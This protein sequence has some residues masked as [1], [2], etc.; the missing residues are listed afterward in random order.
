[1]KPKSIDEYIAAFP[2]K[3]QTILK[4]IRQT[5]RKNAPNASEIISYNMPAFRQNKILIWFAAFK[6]HIGVFPPISGDAKLQKAISPYAGPKGNL[7]FPLDQ[8]FP[9]PLLEKIVK[10]RVKQDQEKSKK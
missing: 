7:K 2:P 1:M 5:V 10:L 9:Y 4:K 6:N 8:P 3:V